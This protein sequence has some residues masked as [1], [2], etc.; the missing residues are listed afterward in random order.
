MES[1]PIGSAAGAHKGSMPNKPTTHTKP[2]ENAMS[3]TKPPTTEKQIMRSEQIQLAKA[4]DIQPEELDGVDLIWYAIAQIERMQ[5]Y[6]NQ[7]E[8]DLRAAIDDE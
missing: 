5:H 3:N 8:A 2:K 6:I 1:A 4:T 7:L